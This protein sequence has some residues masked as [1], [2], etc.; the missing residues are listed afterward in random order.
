MSDFTKNIKNIYGDY[1]TVIKKQSEQEILRNHSH[2]NSSS[3]IDFIKY[4]EESF[5]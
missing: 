4:Y 3:N 5:F 1:S 2:N